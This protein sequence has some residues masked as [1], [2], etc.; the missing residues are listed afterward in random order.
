MLEH[1]KS[2]RFLNTMLEQ[3]KNYDLSKISFGE[4]V[5]NE[6]AEAYC[7]PCSSKDDALKVMKE[8]GIEYDGIE[9]MGGGCVFHKD[10][11][12]LGEYNPDDRNIKVYVELQGTLDQPAFKECVSKCGGKQINEKKSGE[13]Y[14]VKEASVGLSARELIKEF[15]NLSGLFE[16]YMSAIIQ[17]NDKL[18]WK[19]YETQNWR[20][21]NTYEDALKEAQQ[22]IKGLEQT[23]EGRVKETVQKEMDSIRLSESKKPSKPLM[24]KQNKMQSTKEAFNNDKEDAEIIARGISVEEIAQQIADD[25]DGQ[26]IQD[27]ENPEKFAVVKIKNEKVV[28]EHHGKPAEHWAALDAN[29]K[30]DIL[31]KFE[32]DESYLNLSWG[33]YPLGIRELITREMYARGGKQMESINEDCQIESGQ[34]YRDSEGNVYSVDRVEGNDIY[35]VGPDEQEEVI[36]YE[37]IDTLIHANELELIEEPVEDVKPTDTSEAD[38]KMAEMLLIVKHLKEKKN[39]NERENKFMSRVESIH[40]KPEQR[41]RVW[42]RFKKLLKEYKEN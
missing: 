9:E 40:L 32:K 1:R 37:E 13:V 11:S 15:K 25:S 8:A 16:M 38:Q 7:L 26:V 31:K 39:L 10:G 24:E 22:R 6:N 21:F 19:V 29:E 34:K 23:F 2:D 42:E 41:E 5:I 33:Q 3:M 12:V 28:K 20:I 36:K 35:L 14:L 30:L 18:D 17:P 4:P 27:N